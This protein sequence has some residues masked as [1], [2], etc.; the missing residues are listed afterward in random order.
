M[1]KGD[2]IGRD[3]LLKVKKEGVRRKLIGYIVDDKAF[4]RKGYEVYKNGERIGETTSG[5]FSPCLNKGIGIGYVKKEYSEIGSKFDVNIRG[6]NV[7]AEVVKTPF[8]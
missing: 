4:P 3:A 5:T 6:K 2:F 8:V 1:D 7:E